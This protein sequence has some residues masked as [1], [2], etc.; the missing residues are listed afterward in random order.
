MSTFTYDEVGAT[1]NA[2]PLVGYRHLSCRFAVALGAPG[3]RRTA[4]AL[5][6]WQMHEAA[7]L[8]PVASAPRAGAGV[9][10]TSH[11]RL[12]PLTIAAPCQVVWADDTPERAGFAYGTLP[13]H[14]ECGEESFVLTRDGE[15][16]WLTI[17]A[18]SRP[19][20]LLTRLAGPVGPLLQR[21]VTTRYA[22]ALR[23]LADVAP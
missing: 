5:L 8:A 3:L 4:E 2:F 23:R 7:G 17:Q 14:P 16:V 1:R 19:G 9:T 11:L 21:R 12:G 10:V 22:S 13:G 15:I 20:T 6:T 18:F